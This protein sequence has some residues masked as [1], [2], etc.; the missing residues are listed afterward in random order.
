MVF[1]AFMGEN[2]RVSNFTRYGTSIS[3][4]SNIQ[5]ISVAIFGPIGAALSGFLA[6]YSQIFLIKS[7]VT[8]SREEI[9]WKY[10]FNPPQYAL[11][12]LMAG[13]VYLE[14][15]G[16]IGANQNISPDS[17]VI[18]TVL[19]LIGA[20]LA[21]L[22]TNISTMFL[23]FLIEGRRKYFPSAFKAFISSGIPMYLGYIPFGILLAVL[24][25]S[26]RVGAFSAILIVAPIFLG[27]WVFSQVVE[28]RL[29]QER[30]VATLV[31]AVD[32]KD[33][34]TRG[35]SERVAYGVGLIGEACGL[36]E[37]RLDMLQFAGILHDVGKISVPTTILQKDATLTED[38]Y[39]ILAQHPRRGVDIIAD[40]QFL[41]EAYDGI[42]HHHERMDGR[43][44]PHGLAG[45]DI[46]EFARMISVAD[47]FD[48]M[49]STRSYRAARSVSEALDELAHCAGSQFDPYFVNV[50]IAE[51]TAFSW[52]P[53][54]LRENPAE[55]SE[56]IRLQTFE[57]SPTAIDH[58]DPYFSQYW[59]SSKP[60][61]PPESK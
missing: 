54:H 60:S 58:D 15:G 28:Q 32:A 46:P 48:S 9:L 6:L 53:E 10:L 26:G 11:C 56:N 61:G 16:S 57:T 30:I 5:L 24:W 21:I 29:A 35:H 50:F 20:S 3:I 34:Y 47:A 37:N 22:L 25:S 12:G 49:T 44:Y 36:P 43:G 41:S 59:Q 4:S 55:H 51:M 27:R 19:P 38:E 40:I 13:S 33:H 39:K 14:L 45:K 2:S 23:A 42:L 31:Q 18:S 1:I 17:L 8:L 52:P 7:R